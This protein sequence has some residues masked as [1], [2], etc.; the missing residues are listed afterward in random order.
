MSVRSD[1][2]VEYVQIK[3]TNIS[4][5]FAFPSRLSVTVLRTFGLPNR[6]GII[7]CENHNLYVRF[8]STNDNVVYVWAS[9]HKEESWCTIF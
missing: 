4:T 8:D 7:M 1:E 3:G 2:V 9:P 6:H 5:S